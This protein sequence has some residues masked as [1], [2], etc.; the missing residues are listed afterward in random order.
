MEKFLRS[1]ETVLDLPHCEEGSGHTIFEFVPDDNGMDVSLYVL[2]T[3]N[4]F[5]KKY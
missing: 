5:L 4:R 1:H 3:N 2:L